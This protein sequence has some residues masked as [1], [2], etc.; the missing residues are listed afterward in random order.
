MKTKRKPKRRGR[1]LIALGML[2]IFG[3]VGL[4]AYNYWEDFKAE[5]S[6]EM[7][8]QQL[9][10]IRAEN[11]QK[12]QLLS[13]ETVDQLDEGE[14]ALPDPNR[15]MPTVNI[16]G[17]DYIGSIAIIP[18][19]V[20][21]PVT[22]DWDYERMKIATCRYTGTVYLNNLIICAHN[23]STVFGR[24]NNL[25]K[26][27]QVVFIDVEG[28]AYEYRVDKTETLAGTAIEEMKSGDWDLTLFTCTLGGGARVAVRCNRTE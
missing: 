11:T 12:K 25:Q 22:A 26:G 2:L 4:T 24:L 8:M 28:N 21:F 7:I 20:E 10:I 15:E 6:S 9:D 3:G 18:Q 16:D 1:I 19:E 17:Y 5:A 23:Y 14:E 27:D 13:G